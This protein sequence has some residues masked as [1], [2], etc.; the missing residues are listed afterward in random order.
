M[1][2]RT[3]VL[4]L[5]LFASGCGSEIDLQ[6]GQ[7]IAGDDPESYPASRAAG[8]WEPARDAGPPSETAADCYWTQADARVT[9]ANDICLFI[10]CYP[11]NEWSIRRQGSSCAPG[12]VCDGP[13]CVDDN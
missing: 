6:T 7:H 11:D 2:R 1:R 8:T 3:L 4:G 10:E 13:L 9:T 12:M 5:L